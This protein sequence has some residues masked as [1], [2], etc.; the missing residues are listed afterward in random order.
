[1]G[2]FLH[3]IDQCKFVPTFIWLSVI[4]NTSIYN[5]FMWNVEVTLQKLTSNDK[6]FG[7]YIDWDR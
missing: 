4:T 5:N 2:N 3:K 1:M 6:P 7:L